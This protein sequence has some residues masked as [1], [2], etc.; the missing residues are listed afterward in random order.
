LRSVDYYDELLI[1]KGGKT[2]TVAIGKFIDQ[3]MSENPDLKPDDK[4]TWYLDIEDKEPW[5]VVSVDENG[6]VSYKKI[7]AVTRHLPINKDGSNTLLKV[8]TKT[9]KTV[10]ATKAKSFLLRIDN[11]IVPTL[12]EDIKVGHRVPIAYSSFL[13]AKD[14]KSQEY[15]DDIIPGNNTTY[16]KGNIHRNVIKN[17]LDEYENEFTKNDYDTLEMAVNSDVFYDEIVSIEEV[18]SS[19]KF[20]YDLTVAETRNFCLANGFGCHDTFHF[21]GQ[22]Y[23]Y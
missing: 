4:E 6:K 10:T 15:E 19:H 16:V 18:P 2:C 23:Y 8:T 13:E 11:K 9:G 5:E 22:R 21:T 17:I 20:V 12:G 1:R 14:L 7:E 3:L